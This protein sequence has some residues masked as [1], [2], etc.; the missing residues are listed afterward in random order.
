MPAWNW[1]PVPVTVEQLLTTGH[2]GVLA[3]ANLEPAAAFTICDV[4]V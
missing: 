2:L 3:I 1:F 4:W